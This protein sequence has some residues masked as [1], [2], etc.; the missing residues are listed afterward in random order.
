MKKVINNLW[1]A[2]KDVCCFIKEPALLSLLFIDLLSM[3]VNILLCDI[4]IVIINFFFAMLIA[5]ILL[6]R[7]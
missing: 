2:F 5:K 4:V 7:Y 3:V 6:G 1:L